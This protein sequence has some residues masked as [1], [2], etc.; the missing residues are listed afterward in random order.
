MEGAG[1][2]SGDYKV[3]FL[4]KEF[5]SHDLKTPQRPHVLILSSWRV[6]IA[7]YVFWEDT[8]PWRIDTFDLWSWKRLLRTPWTAK[9]SDQP[10]LKE[11][12]PE[13]SFE[14]LMLKLKLQYSGHLMWSVNSLEKT[15][16]LGKIE[17]WR[18]RGQEK[19]RSLDGITDSVD[20]SL[21]KFWE[22][23]KY[24]EAWC[25][26]IQGITN[27][28]TWQWLNNGNNDLSGLVKDQMRWLKINYL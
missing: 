12:N 17:G 10:I 15:L 11:I 14:G 22:I 28:W 26:A 9:R 21:S 18:R 25:A 23:V 7:L 8:K 27:S 1:D 4:S 13:Y 3:L 20:M 5:Y 24:K 2:I 6:R 16:M 19:K